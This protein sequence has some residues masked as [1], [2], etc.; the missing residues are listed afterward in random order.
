MAR[1]R[2]GGATLSAE[3]VMQLPNGDWLMRA[4]GRSA[5]FEKGD[6]IRVK[7]YEIIEMAAAEMPDGA[8]AAPAI[9]TQKV[10]DTEM[11]TGSKLAE[12]AELMRDINKEI[13]DGSQSA[14]DRLQNARKK[15]R[16]G[17]G[18]L[19]GHI[20]VIDKGVKDVEDVANQLSNFNPDT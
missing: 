17:L 16:E 9:A 10:K 8:Q 12:L 5:R 18:K 2:F 20:D 6:S 7:P 13:D 4:M 1:V 15:A 14:L 11:A 19:H 3:P